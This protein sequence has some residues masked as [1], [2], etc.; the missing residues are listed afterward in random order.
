MWKRFC[1]KRYDR[2]YTVNAAGILAFF[3]AIFIHKRARKNHNGENSKV[4]TVEGQ[5]PVMS[6]DDIYENGSIHG[7]EDEDDIEGVPRRPA[8]MLIR[9][10]AEKIQIIDGA[11]VPG[12]GFK[13]T[14][15]PMAAKTVDNIRK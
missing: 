2:D 13:I 15:V 9:T 4:I 10:A 12:S 1:D 8:T 5:E 14:E 7:T 3:K 11:Q 6:D